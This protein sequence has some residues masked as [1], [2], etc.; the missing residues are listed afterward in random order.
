MVRLWALLVCAEAVL[1][2]IL[3]HHDFT[4]TLLDSIIEDVRIYVYRPPPHLEKALE[5]DAPPQK[6]FF[7]YARLETSFL[8]GLR[9]LSAAGH[10]RFVDDPLQADCFWV[11]HTLH[12]HWCVCMCTHSH[13]MCLS[14]CVCACVCKQPKW[15][16]W[17]QYCPKK[18]KEGCRI[19][20]IC[21]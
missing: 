14:N 1:A 16:E 15:I 10:G 4:V 8:A 12:A 11:P 18:D 2:S 9:N 20:E 19:F 5:L 7:H 21:N 6:P 17:M 13:P 3:R